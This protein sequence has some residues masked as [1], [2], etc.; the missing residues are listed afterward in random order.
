MR[1]DKFY[2]SSGIN[3]EYGRMKTK[4][5]TNKPVSVL[6]LSGNKLTSFDVPSDTNVSSTADAIR[7]VLQLPSSVVMVLNNQAVSAFTHVTLEQLMEDE[8]GPTKSTLI[9]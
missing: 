8:E 1:Y 3:A 2:R 5:N 6:G 7:Q 4:Q 9:S